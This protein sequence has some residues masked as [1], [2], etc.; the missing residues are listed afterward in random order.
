[1]NKLLVLLILA[2]GLS[3]GACAT[4]TDLTEGSRTYAWPKSNMRYVALADAMSDIQQSGHQTAVII[5]QNRGCEHCEVMHTVWKEN[6]FRSSQPLYLVEA[7]T[8]KWMDV[9]AITELIRSDPIKLP[10]CLVVQNQRITGFVT[11]A[12][13]CTKAL[14]VR[15]ESNDE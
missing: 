5:L 2:L 13:G 6:K 9:A 10:T 3:L 14:A 4:T 12:A 8:L 11:G 15:P 1:M 7:N